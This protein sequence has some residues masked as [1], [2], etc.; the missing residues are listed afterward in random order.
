[1]IPTL[2]KKQELAL[3]LYCADR[4]GQAYID[5]CDD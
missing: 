1:M 3:D 5:E 4:F 2:T